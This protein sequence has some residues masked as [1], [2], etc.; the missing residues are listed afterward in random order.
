MSTEHSISIRAGAKVVGHVEGE[1]FVK[2]VSASK[3]QLRSPR[4]WAL[5]VQSLQD[6]EKAGAK[7]VELRDTETGNTYAASIALIRAKGIRLNRGWGE[8]IACPLTM[9]QVHIPG[10]RQLEFT[11]C[12]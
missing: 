4:G 9:W 5:D 11:L 2:K 12:A 10:I 7:T 1:R 6:A 8:Q 3:H